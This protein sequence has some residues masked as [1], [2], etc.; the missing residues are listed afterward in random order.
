M[1]KL[2]SDCDWIREH[3]CWNPEWGPEPEGT[4]TQNPTLEQI[5]PGGEPENILFKHPDLIELQARGDNR[6]DKHPDAEK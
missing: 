1:A 4:W 6:D 3:H 2:K 5:F